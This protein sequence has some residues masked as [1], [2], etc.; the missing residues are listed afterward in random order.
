[1]FLP[2]FIGLALFLRDKRWR[3]AALGGVA[4]LTMALLL[5]YSRQAYFIAVLG[6]AVLLLRRSVLL[7]IVLGATLAS[8]VGFLPESVTQRVEETQQKG[9]HGEEKVDEGVLGAA[10]RQRVEARF[11]QEG[12]R[13]DPPRMGRV[14]QQ[15]RRIGRRLDHV[16]G[17]AELDFHV[18][19]LSAPARRTLPA[20]KSRAPAHHKQN[21]PQISIFGHDRGRP[22]GV[23]RNAI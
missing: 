20:R 6:L 18:M 9:P 12:S 7:A 16:E 23:N 11:G 3:I 2:M 19:T 17:G 8:L 14:E 1:M 5:T 4:L 15:G 22:W 13:I 10:Q 21:L